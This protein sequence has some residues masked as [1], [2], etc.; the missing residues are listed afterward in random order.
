MVFRS[1]ITDV[2]VEDGK[3]IGVETKDN[4]YYIEFIKLCVF[5]VFYPIMW[6]L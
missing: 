3:C 4:K 1:P 6:L 5:L 2:I